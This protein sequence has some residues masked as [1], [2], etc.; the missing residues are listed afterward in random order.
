MTR[1]GLVLGFFNLLLS[2]QLYNRCDML[3][4]FIFSLLSSFQ[5]IKV[6]LCDH[7]AVCVCPRINF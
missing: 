6:G 3:Q 2:I 5:K 4:V 1:H 7:H